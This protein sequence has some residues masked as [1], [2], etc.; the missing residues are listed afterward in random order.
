[1]DHFQSCNKKLIFISKKTR[2]RKKAKS[3]ITLS[4]AEQYQ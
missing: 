3:E 2:K 1:M 4:E